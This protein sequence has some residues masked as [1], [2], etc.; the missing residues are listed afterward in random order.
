MV[1][2]KGVKLL[3]GLVIAIVVGIIGFSL[4]QTYIGKGEI[5]STFLFLFLGIVSVGLVMLGIATRE[6]KMS[7]DT[8]IPL[9]LMIGTP[10]VILFLLPKL[11]IH[12]FS[13]LGIGGGVNVE[14]NFTGTIALFIKKYIVFFAAGVV[15]LFWQR[16]NITKWLRRTV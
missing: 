13:T 12:L 3:L 2:G 9:I 16:D 10:I 7:L 1:E 15:L 4:Y 5:S 14:L 6:A 11:G 8:L